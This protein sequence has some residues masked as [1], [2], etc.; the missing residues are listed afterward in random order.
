MNLLKIP[1]LA[2]ARQ[3]G[4]TLIE[5]LVTVVVLAIGLLG[6]AGLQLTGMQYNHSAYQRSQATILADDITDRMRVNRNI[7]LTGAYDVAIGVNLPN[8]SCDGLGAN[9]TPAALAAAD[10]STWKQALANLLPS[11]D[12]AITRNG[13]NFTITVQWDDSRGTQAPKTL[14]VVTTL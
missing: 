9:C 8:S 3:R 5:I 14:A 11:G 2:T 1:T 4:F 13:N 6:L 12:G 10:L 7:A